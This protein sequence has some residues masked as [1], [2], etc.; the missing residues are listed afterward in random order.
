[1]RFRAYLNPPDANGA[2]LEPPIPLGVYPHRTCDLC[3]RG[4]VQGYGVP[5][6]FTKTGATL[7]LLCAIYAAQKAHLN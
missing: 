1:M 2:R 4:S 5:I 6:H 3:K 7:H